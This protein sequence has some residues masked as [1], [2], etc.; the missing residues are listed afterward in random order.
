MAVGV[1]TT[2]KLEC[3]GEGEGKSAVAFNFQP[4]TVRYT[5]IFPTSANCQQFESKPSARAPAPI[6]GQ[7]SPTFYFLASSW[8][9]LKSS[10]DLAG[11]P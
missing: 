8:P 11:C 9:V 10:H 1:G 2:N 6:N 4:I 5:K 3:V 7:L